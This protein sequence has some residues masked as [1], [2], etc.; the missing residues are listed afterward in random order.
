MPDRHTSS[1]PACD[2]PV[3]HVRRVVD[4][5]EGTE[6]TLP[7][8]PTPVVRHVLVRFPEHDN[9]VTVGFEELNWRILQQRL[10][11]LRRLREQDPAMVVYA[12][13]DV[14]SSSQ[15]SRGEPT[16][17]YRGRW[18]TKT[19]P[20]SNETNLVVC[21]TFEGSATNCDSNSSRQQQLDSAQPSGR[22]STASTG[23]KRQREN[24]SNYVFESD[25]EIIQRTQRTITEAFP[26][27]A[28]LTF[29]RML[30]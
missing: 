7:I 27:D 21:Q 17:L 30:I 1:L 15:A 24:P 2:P 26:I 6:V 25:S 20:L 18:H 8:P 29:N 28:V 11:E 10:I 5:W 22:K 23:A 19:T 14:S 16:H 9:F 3:R 4:L 13:A 12:P